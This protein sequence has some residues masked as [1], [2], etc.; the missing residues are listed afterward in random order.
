M[1]L[2]ICMM[3]KNS[4]KYIEQSLQ[5]I[6]PVIE[7]LNAEIVVI[8]TGSNDKTV[9]I[10]KKYTDKIYY[11]EWNDNFSEIKNLLIKYACGEWLLFLDSD[12]IVENPNELINFIKSMESN[13]YNTAT[14]KIKNFINDNNEKNYVLSTVLRM[15]RKDKD[16]FYKGAIHEQPMFKFP[17]YNLNLYVKHYGYIQNDKK[18]IE[19]KFKRNV[20]LLEKELLNNDSDKIYIY[21]QLAVSYTMYEKYEDALNYAQKAYQEAVNNKV[22][23]RNRMYVYLTLIKLYYLNDNYLE[24]KKVAEEALVKNDK[25]ID[26]YYILAIINNKLFNYD[27]SIKNYLKYLELI[28]QYN[29]NELNI[30]NDS[31]VNFDTLTYKDHVLVDLCI[32]LYKTQ[33]YMNFLDYY[34]KIEDINLSSKLFYEYINTYLKINEISELKKYYDNKILSLNLIEVENRFE[35]ALEKYLQNNKEIY[36]NLINIFC[37]GEKNYNILNKVRKKI[38]MSD[39]SSDEYILQQIIKLDFNNLP[40]FYGDIIYYV[41]KCKLNLFKIIKDVRENKL[42]ELLMYCT[43]KYNDLNDILLSFAQQFNEY[44]SIAQLRIIKTIKK[45]LLIND[46]LDDNKEILLSFINDG[47][48]YINNIYNKNILDFEFFN[49]VVNNEHLFFIYIYKAL[50]IKDYEIKKSIQYLKKALQVY[51]DYKKIVEYL[52]DELKSNLN[53]TTSEFEKCK[54]VFKHNI[55]ILLEANKLS[56]ALMLINEYLAIVPDDVE[57]INLKCKLEMIF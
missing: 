36:N 46:I 17:I 45:V 7:Q 41:F 19:Y 33:N 2:S 54:K 34:N 40:I 20:K 37:D 44:N 48:D 11:H 52:L 51:P 15:F 3:T 42:Y 28:E 9:E 31:S 5:S 26:I 39:F 49:D 24:A 18:L 43:E 32:L 23:L 21:Y 35:E 14:I 30:I 29:N 56:E 25:Y 47:I 57:I 38:I 10:V 13:K 16:F 50:E 27:E 6:K 8:D 1:K 55:N 53:D 12:E 22:D 4:E